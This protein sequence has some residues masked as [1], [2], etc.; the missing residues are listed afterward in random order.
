MG[1]R[2]SSSQ[3]ISI[4]EIVLIKID[5]RTDLI[6]RKF[7]TCNLFL[8]DGRFR[9]NRAKILRRSHVQS[10]DDKRAIGKNKFS[11]SRAERQGVSRIAE[12]RINKF[13]R[14]LTRL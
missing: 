1:G 3:R 7:F 11:G 6:K 5:E 9:L 4:Y 14:Q 2:E 13:A 8:K 10:G 12:K